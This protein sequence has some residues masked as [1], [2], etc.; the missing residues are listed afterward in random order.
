MKIKFG[1]QKHYS[2]LWVV[3]IITEVGHVLCSDNTRYLFGVKWTPLS[4][5]RTRKLARARV[6]ILKAEKYVFPGNLFR[7]NKY[8]R[9]E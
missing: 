5:H 9:M 1:A 2:D 8:K 7:I 6:N 3:E 4:M